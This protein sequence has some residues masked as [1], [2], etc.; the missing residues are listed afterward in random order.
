MLLECFKKTWIEHSNDV[1]SSDSKL[2]RDASSGS[3]SP[4]FIKHKFCGATK[5]ES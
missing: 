4:L 2:S 5:S 1:D 3:V